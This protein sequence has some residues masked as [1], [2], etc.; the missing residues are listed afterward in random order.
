VVNPDGPRNGFFPLQYVLLERGSCAV[1]ML[2]PD[3][4]ETVKDGI[5]GIVGHFAIE[6][7]D[8]DAVMQQLKAAGLLAEDAKPALFPHLYKGSRATHIN[9]PSGEIIELFEYKR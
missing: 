9:G 8:L 2:Q 1:E 3:D 6:V 7:D 5:E 4:I